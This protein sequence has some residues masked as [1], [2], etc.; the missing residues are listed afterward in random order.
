MDSIINIV[1]YSLLC[2]LGSNNEEVLN[3]LSNGKT[4]VKNRKEY[5]YPVSTFPDEWLKQVEEKDSK[6][7]L[8]FLQKSLILFIEKFIN[9]SPELKKI[10]IEDK[11][12]CIIYWSTTKAGIGENVYNLNSFLKE[13]L[14][15]FSWETLPN[16]I[17]STAC[18]S[19]GLALREANE[20]L[21]ISDKK[22]A[23]IIAFDFLSPF[24]MDGFNAFKALSDSVCMPFHPERKGLNL[25]EAM[26]AMVL[27]KD[28]NRS[29]KASVLASAGTNDANHLSGPS[30]TGEELAKAI[31]LCFKNHCTSD[32]Q[33]VM[34]HGTATLFN[35]E[36][37]SKA[38]YLS[39]LGSVPFIA[40]KYY[41][42]HS[43]GA[44]ALVE[45]ILG[46]L[47]LENN[48]TIPHPYF[49]EDENPIFNKRVYSEFDNSKSKRFIKT[50]SGFG[51]C[52]IALLL[53]LH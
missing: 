9:S 34:A 22:H 30:R 16:R 53:E 20:E 31:E 44:S 36:M 35:D 27:T 47:I 50:A 49:S 13:V 8:S 6:I 28:N 5:L 33:F 42:G 1:D 24:I 11:K 37:E 12:N 10:L 29:F 21:K 19:G 14:H 18:I 41:L 38:H 4:S 7:S 43:L 45:I 3:A 46:L 51:G 39:G 17:V 52:N 23:I 15:Y 48:I 32:L 2:G 40:P 25:G 26:A